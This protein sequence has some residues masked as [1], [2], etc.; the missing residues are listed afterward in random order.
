M[1][2]LLEFLLY[3]ITDLPK[4]LLM[5]VK[6]IVMLFY[7]IILSYLNLAYELLQIPEI[8]HA[9]ALKQWEQL[10]G[11]LILD[12]FVLILLGFIAFLIGF[13]M[14]VVFGIPALYLYQCVLR[15]CYKIKRNFGLFAYNKKYLKWLEKRKVALILEPNK[16]IY[17]KTEQDA[18]GVLYRLLN[19]NKYFVKL[20]LFRELSM[21][22]LLDKYD[23]LLAAVIDSVGEIIHYD[24]VTYQHMVCPNYDEVI[25]SYNASFG[26][27]AKV[28]IAHTH[29]PSNSRDMWYGTYSKR[30]PVN[31]RP[32][33]E[34]LALTLETMKK[35]DPV[36]VKYEFILPG[37]TNG[38]YRVIKPEKLKYLYEK[39]GG[40]DNIDVDEVSLPERNKK[41]KK[42]L[43]LFPAEDFD[44]VY[45][46]TQKDEKLEPTFVGM[47]LKYKNLPQRIK[48]QAEG[49]K[50]WVE[51]QKS[52]KS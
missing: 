40:L 14:Y 16:D 32:S 15:I 25:Y 7:R 26:D 10:E 46:A 9:F 1:K 44:V 5:L 34:D 43:K 19:H 22:L 18:V 42:L 23:K 4:D 52:L 28:V 2:D 29:P 8:Q 31:I 30:S 13:A 33:R 3:L 12:I 11:I 37:I 21:I 41:Y 27:C 36:E 50:E 35:L 49:L 47:K 51:K 20:A 6:D 39:R 38:E 48:S 45:D 17:I 24:I